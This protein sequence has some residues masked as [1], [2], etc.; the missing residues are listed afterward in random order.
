MLN[1][2][3]L[4]YFNNFKRS[5][6]FNIQKNREISDTQSYK[7]ETYM[8]SYLAGVLNNGNKIGNGHLAKDSLHISIP[9]QDLFD[10]AQSN[11]LVYRFSKKHC[12]SCVVAS[13]EVLKRQ[14][15]SI[16][17]RNIA[18]LGNYRN[19]RIYQRTLKEYGIKK[20]K[21]LNSVPFNIPAE[22]IG[23]PYF[24][25]L[26]NNL[27]IADVFIPNKTTP[28]ITSKYLKLIKEKYF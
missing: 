19:N 9:I 13:M 8:S 27:E 23:Y 25:I 3:S 6:E 2:Y 16:G 26:K 17:G 24:F 20:V 11:I 1:I 4:F 10:K 14:I 5:S 21:A 15:D 22:E 28:N 12:E 7:L 18:F